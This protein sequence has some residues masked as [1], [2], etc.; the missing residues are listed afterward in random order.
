MSDLHP[1]ARAL[2]EAAKRGETSFPADARARVHR[3][4]LR[5]A[6]ALG[7]AVATTSTVSAASKAGALVAALT[8]P[9]AIPGVVGAVA[10][11]AFFVLRAGSAPPEP[12]RVASMASPAPSHVSAVVARVPPALAPAA[13]VETA[14]A[15]EPEPSAPIAVAATTSPPLATSRR[16]GPL[17]TEPVAQPPA[18]A[19]DSPA[20][21]V[22]SEPVAPVAA[23]AVATSGAGVAAPAA[24]AQRAATTAADL[25]GDLDL[26]RRVHEALRAGRSQAALS[27]LD[28]EGKGLDAG[29]LAEEAQGARVSALCQLGR[30]AEARDATS[31]FLATWP[32][33]PLAMRLRGGCAALGT[34]SKPEGD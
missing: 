32:T 14:A 15:A 1:T 17:A 13:P 3:S 18:A 28:R 4:V 8:G 20:G 12:Q 26:L 11:V 16:P 19:M 7:A 6:A 24:P 22:A 23:A 34:N 29:P 33:S 2:I 10:G 31:R 30:V 21:M 25:A 5:R 9:F 27:L